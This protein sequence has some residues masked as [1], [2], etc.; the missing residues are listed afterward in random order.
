M[1]PLVIFVILGLLAGCRDR[2]EEGY[3]AGYAD[4]MVYGVEIAKERA[5]APTAVEQSKSE[6]PPTL[7]TEVCGGG[8]VTVDGKHYRP[9]KTGCARVMGDGTVQRY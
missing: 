3:R 1:N 4:G 9:G 2:F 8:G 6:F 7:T 5:R